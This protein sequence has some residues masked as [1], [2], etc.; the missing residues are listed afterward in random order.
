MIPA[1]D[2]DKGKLASF[3]GMPSPK[4]IVILG[5]EHDYAFAAPVK[6]FLDR[7]GVS[8]DFRVASAHKDS[9][10]LIKMLE[11]YE[12][13]DERIVYITVAGMSNA[14][15]GF[16]DFKT[17]HPV[18]AC[19]PPSM[20]LWHIDIYS[21][22]RMPRGVAPLVTC[23]PE[24]AALAALKMLGECDSD[25]ARKV[26]DYQREIQ[27]GNEKADLKVSRTETG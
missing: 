10:R 1:A 24:N 9:E 20:D 13:L 6:S 22:L 15:S 17:R 26:R 14:L 19:P 25:L 3:R 2:K 11:A 21:S 23:D 16:V 7:F 27:L 8:C 5:S 4:V 12:K 18:I